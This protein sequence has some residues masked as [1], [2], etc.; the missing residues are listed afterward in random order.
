MSEQNSTTKTERQYA[1]L[2]TPRRNHGDLAK[3]PEGGTLVLVQCQGCPWHGRNPVAF[4]VFRFAAGMRTPAVGQVLPIFHPGHKAWWGDWK[5]LATGTRAKGAE[6][7]KV[8]GTVP[9]ASKG[10]GT[11]W[12]IRPVPAAKPATTAQPAAAKA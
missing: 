9:E 1:G 6:E 8:T 4:R 11:L 2:T 7:I 10:K 5:V 12:D 3:V